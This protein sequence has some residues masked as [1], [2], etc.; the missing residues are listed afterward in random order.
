MYKRQNGARIRKVINHIRIKG[1][2]QNLVANSKGY[3]IETD[4]QSIENYK[5][6]LRDRIAS[7]QAVLNS[8][9]S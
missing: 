4:V 9:E 3:Y 1:L 8:F 5:Q 7:I 6:S 2:V